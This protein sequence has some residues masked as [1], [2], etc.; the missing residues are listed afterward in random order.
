[1]V[2]YIWFLFIAALL[3]VTLVSHEV[4]GELDVR[5]AAETRRQL[6]L[7]SA[8]L[9]LFFTVEAVLRFTELAR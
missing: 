3:V 7:V 8:P 9:L 4:L 6:R 1:M 5:G 2:T